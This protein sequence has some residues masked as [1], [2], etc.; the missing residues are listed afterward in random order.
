MIEGATYVVVTIL[1]RIAGF[2]C[3]VSACDEMNKSPCPIHCQ[4]CG[5]D[6]KKGHTWVDMYR[7]LVADD[8][9]TFERWHQRLCAL[10]E[11]QFLR[12]EPSDLMASE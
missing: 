7:H 5:W 10:W 4:R 9:P 12:H 6:L 2:N 11:T 8:L 1:H 3:V